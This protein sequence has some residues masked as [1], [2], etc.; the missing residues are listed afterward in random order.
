M[1]AWITETVGGWTLIPTP[2]PRESYIGLSR[3]AMGMREHPFTQGSPSLSMMVEQN[4][5]DPDGEEVP[6]SFK[7]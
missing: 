4:E 2:Y 6:P 1:V 5:G 7:G 3:L